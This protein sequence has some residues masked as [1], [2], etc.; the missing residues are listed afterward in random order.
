MSDRILEMESKS[1]LRNSRELEGPTQ[2]VAGKLSGKLID[3]AERKQKN[4]CHIKD[5]AH[6]SLHRCSC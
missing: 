3:A 5:P 2:Q 1:T 4:R 6:N